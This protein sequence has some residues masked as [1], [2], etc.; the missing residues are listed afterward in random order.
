MTGCGAT[1]AHTEGKHAVAS[2]LCRERRQQM[3]IDNI[4]ELMEMNSR[5][6]NANAPGGRLRLL[7]LLPPDGHL[8]HGQHLPARRRVES[9]HTSRCC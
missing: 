3:I 2:T 7:Q 5:I 1:T 8:Q 4:I 6:C 9:D